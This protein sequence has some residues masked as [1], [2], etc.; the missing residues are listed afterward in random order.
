[1]QPLGSSQIQIMHRRSSRVLSQTIIFI[2]HSVPHFHTGDLEIYPGS[3]FGR[4]SST[5][6]LPTMTDSTRSLVISSGDPG[7]QS[8]KLPHLRA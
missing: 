4:R 7:D 5:L 6:D 3:R 2:A 8:S 1:M